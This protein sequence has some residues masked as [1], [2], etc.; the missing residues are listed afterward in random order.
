AAQPFAR[1]KCSFRVRLR[2]L[3]GVQATSLATKTEIAGA[4]QLH[5]PGPLRRRTPLT[6]ERRW[7]DVARYSPAHQ[8]REQKMGRALPSS[9]SSRPP[10]LAECDSIPSLSPVI[11]PVEMAAVQAVNRR[12]HR[13]FDQDRTED[14]VAIVGLYPVPIEHVQW[15]SP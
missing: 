9:D 2:C 4:S 11:A 10:A 5:G 13:G 15:P 7:S 1:R 3:A 14:F 8:W 12:E 6:R